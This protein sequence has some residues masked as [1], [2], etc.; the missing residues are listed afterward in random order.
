M[1]HRFR[2]AVLVL[3]GVALVAW[4]AIILAADDRSTALRWALLL[5]GWCTVAVRAANGAG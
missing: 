2:L 3:Y 5:A 1:M 4:A